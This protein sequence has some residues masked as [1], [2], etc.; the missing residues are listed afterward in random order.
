MFRIFLLAVL[1]SHACFHSFPIVSLGGSGGTLS[2][3]DMVVKHIFIMKSCKD[4]ICNNRPEIDSII[5]K[6]E[7]AV[8]DGGNKKQLR[9]EA[10]GKIAAKLKKNIPKNKC[11]HAAFTG[12]FFG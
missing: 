3:P 2:C 11:S 1:I 9:S 6:Y 8:R 12:S 5:D 10:E 4:Q 7:K